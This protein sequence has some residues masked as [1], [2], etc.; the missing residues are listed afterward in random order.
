MGLQN[1]S[2]QERKIVVECL[3]AASE[4]PFFPD[5]EFPILFGLNRP[6][7]QSILGDESHLDDSDA[8]VS[9]AINNSFV[10]LLGYPHGKT[11]EWRHWISVDPSVVE[12]IFQKWR[13]AA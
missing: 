11:T 1:L 12:E 9:L 4:G 13:G 8:N 3:R 10:N 7:I 5:W 2:E 6:D